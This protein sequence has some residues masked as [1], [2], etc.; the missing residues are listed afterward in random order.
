MAVMRYRLA[1]EHPFSAVVGGKE[2]VTSAFKAVNLVFV[3]EGS[4][5]HEA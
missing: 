4:V 2:G 5:C 3:L 1:P